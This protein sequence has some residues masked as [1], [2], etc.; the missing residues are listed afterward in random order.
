MIYRDLKTTRR[1]KRRERKELT[2][3]A[4]HLEA[5][6]C[7]RNEHLEGVKKLQYKVKNFFRK[8]SQST[9]S[10]I[11]DTLSYPFTL[12]ISILYKDPANYDTKV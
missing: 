9:V 8:V 6:E 12:L 11:S 1:D 5:F 4:R 10:K 7:I 3:I 2:K